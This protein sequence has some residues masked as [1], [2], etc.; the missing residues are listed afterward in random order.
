MHMDSM[1]EFKGHEV[2]KVHRNVP[3]NGARD[4]GEGL[5]RAILSGNQQN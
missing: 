2:S 1:D 3:S 5:N 4:D